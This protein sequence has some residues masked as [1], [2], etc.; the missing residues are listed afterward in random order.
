MVAFGSEITR[1]LSDPCCRGSDM[2]HPF[3]VVDAEH[4][5]RM[6]SVERYNTIFEDTYIVLQ[7]PEILSSFYSPRE[8]SSSHLDLALE[9]HPLSTKHY[10]SW[11]MPPVDHTKN[12]SDVT[13]DARRRFVTQLRGFRRTNS[14]SKAEP[15]AFKDY[16][17]WGTITVLDE[18]IVGGSR[19]EVE[20]DADDFRNLLDVL[21]GEIE[22]I[23]PNIR[24]G[25]F[26][27]LQVYNHLLD[28]THKCGHLVNKWKDICVEF[29]NETAAPTSNRYLPNGS[30]TYQNYVT[31]FKRLKNAWLE[32]RFGGGSSTQYTDC[33]K[34]SIGERGL[35]GGYP[36]KMRGP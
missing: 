34:Q 22:Y 14:S 16:N 30:Y 24:L 7:S 1:S 5:F 36:S 25:R 13:F 4:E 21:L 31:V 2:T 20:E 15:P 32:I 28:N 3:D 35:V 11:N 26:E 27:L 23:N 6:S 8:K 33:L 19:L 18:I 17:L 12:R 9:N 10:I 29:L